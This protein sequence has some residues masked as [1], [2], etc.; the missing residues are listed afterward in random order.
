MVTG[1][2]SLRAPEYSPISS[3]VSEVRLTSSSRH[4]RALTVLVTRI[5]VVV[6]ERA[7]APGAD[8]GL[9]RA[10]GEHDDARAAVE[11]A[12]DGLLL[13]RPQVPAVLEQVD[14]VRLAV[15]VAREV[16]GRPAELEQHLLEVAALGRV[17]DD[18]GR[19]DAG[20]EQAGG[21]LGADHLDQHRRVE[22]VQDQA[23]HRVLDQLQAAV[24]GHRVGDVDQQR[25]R[26]RVAGV[27][28][29]DVDDLLGVVAGGAR[30]PQAQR[31]Q[32]VGVHVLRGALELGERGDRAAAGLG[33]VVVDLE[34]ERLVALHDQGTVGHVDSSSG[35]WWAVR[36]PSWRSAQAV[37]AGQWCRA[38]SG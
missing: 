5:R 10:A 36:S 4:C 7:M 29:Q 24:A 38:S 13:V 33:L 1:R 8:E 27:L 11:E 26:D 32:A 30:V 20:A 6:D 23:V 17:D 14:L 3:S 22:R 12:V 9:A 15:D 2:I 18:V 34:Q 25:V 28:E 19:V 16:L 31:G 35:S 21:A 37:G